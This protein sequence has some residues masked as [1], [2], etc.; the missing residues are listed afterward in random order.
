MLSLAPDL[1]IG[2]TLAI[3]R[4]SGNIPCL[5]ETLKIWNRIFFKL[6][7]ATIIMF[8]LKSSKP[9]ALFCFKLLNASSN[10]SKLIRQTAFF[11]Y[12]MSKSLEI[13]FQCSGFFSPI[14]VKQ[15]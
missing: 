15:K 4:L 12:E 14:L 13:I 6:L 8:L 5:I 2:V 3:F 11:H 9:A 1:N 10:S 7:Y